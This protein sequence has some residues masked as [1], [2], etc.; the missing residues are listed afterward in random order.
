M[1]RLMVL[2]AVVAAC[3]K[4]AKTADVDLFGKTP[5]PPGELAKITP[6]MTQAQLEAAFPSAHPTPNHSGSPSLRIDSGYD[7][8]DYDVVFYSDKD[9]VASIDVR[10][11][12]ELAAKLPTAW[13]PGDKSALGETWVDDVDGYEA[14]VMEMGRRTNVSFRPFVPLTAAYFGK[15][16]ALPGNWKAITFGAKE[17]EVHPG[18]ADEPRDVAIHPRYSDDA[19]QAVSIDLPARATALLATAWGP[20]T[21][22]GDTTVWFDDAA[23]IRAT[24][25]GTELVLEPYETY[26]KLFGTGPGDL[27]DVPVAIEGTS[28]AE[29]IAALGPR[30]RTADNVMLQYGMPKYGG[31]YAAMNCLFFPEARCDLTVPYETNTAARDEMLAYLVS[32]WGEPTKVDKDDRWFKVGGKTLRVDDWG[33]QLKI[34]VETK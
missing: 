20:G 1:T 13:G 3:G 6:G 22:L 2:V 9:A 4:S 7:N 24:L 32:I 29:V 28:K 27:G 33:G 16:P 21:K 15:A 23:G 11:P 31:Q 17:T 5:R 30:V 8:I 10:V 26:A 19:L 12:K 18:T 34:S 14:R 25:A